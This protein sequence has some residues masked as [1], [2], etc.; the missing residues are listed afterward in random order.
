MSTRYLSN[1]AL[2]LAAGFLV[3][4]TQAWAPPAAAGITFGV[5]IGFTVIGLAMLAHRVTVQRVLAG[6]V[7][8]IGAWTVIA[9]LVFVPTT[10]LWLGFASALAVVA[11]SVI[12][13]TA[14]ELTTER[15]VH[16]LE[17]RREPVS[18]A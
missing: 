15:V 16:S 14:H 11:L 13:M 5:A 12:G 7:T 6:L 8:V 3:V 2:I 4:A 10:A 1:L 18:A 9:S 17:V